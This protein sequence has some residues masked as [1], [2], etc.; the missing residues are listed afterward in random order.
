MLCHLGGGHSRTYAY[1]PDLAPKKE[2]NQRSPRPMRNL[3]TVAALLAMTKYFL[4][5]SLPIQVILKSEANVTAIICC[6]V[7]LLAIAIPCLMVKR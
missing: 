1:Q 5:D 7:A 4:L 6:V 3:F 2:P